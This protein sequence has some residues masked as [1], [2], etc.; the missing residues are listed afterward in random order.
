MV[1]EKKKSGSILK[2]II[3]LA[4]ILIAVFALLNWQYIW[5]NL[6]YYVSGVSS[7]S[8]TADSFPISGDEKGQPN[9]LSIPSLGIQAPI[10]YV[11]EKSESVYQDALQRGVVHF[12]GTAKPGEPGNI[13]IFGH[14]SD[15]VFSKGDYKAVFALLPKIEI[16][17]TVQ[18]SD[19]QGNE[20]SYEVLES[21]ATASDDLSVLDQRDYQKRLLTVQT[22]YPIGT[23]LRRWIVVAELIE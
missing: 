14:S 6:K 23:A 20:Y 8:N 13:Y 19:E 12:P 21:F 7:V 1:G 17:A 18:I 10:I 3:T 2:K 15:Y 9:N 4:I 22:S 16:G 11:D 5:I